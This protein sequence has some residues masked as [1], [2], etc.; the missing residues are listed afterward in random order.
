[1]SG[2]NLCSILSMKKGHLREGG[3]QGLWH[4]AVMFKIELGHADQ[5]R[6]AGVFFDEFPERV[7][8]TTVIFKRFGD[9]IGSLQK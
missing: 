4:P 2:V 3:L 6:G 5:P 9:Y 1:M 8:L 7:P